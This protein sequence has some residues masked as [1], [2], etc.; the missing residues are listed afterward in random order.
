MDA[1][2]ALLAAGVAPARGDRPAPAAPAAPAGG[3]G[4]D[5]ARAAREMEALFVVQLMKAMRKTVPESGLLTGGRGEEIMRSIQDETLAQAVAARG[6]MGL[7][8]RLEETLARVN[9]APPEGP[10]DDR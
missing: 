7:A 9:P 1:L 4:V 8:E 6:G 5:N 2:G 3:D 10:E